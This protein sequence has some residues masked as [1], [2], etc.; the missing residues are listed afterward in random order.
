[1]DLRI[2]V[3]PL[4]I[5]VGRLNLTMCA[6]FPSDLISQVFLKKRY[7]KGFKGNPYP[8]IRFQLADGNPTQ[9]HIVNYF[10]SDLI[11]EFRHQFPRDALATN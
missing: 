2:E 1:M 3:D 4:L 8:L 9:S 5:R 6:I 11:F 7:F 10:A